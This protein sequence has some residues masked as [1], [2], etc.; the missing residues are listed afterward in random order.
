MSLSTTTGPVGFRYSEQ[1]LAQW[2]DVAQHYDLPS[3]V[4]SLS[5]VTGPA[6]RCR[7]AL[8]LARQSDNG[9][10]W[11]SQVVGEHYK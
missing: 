9:A 11:P 3:G 7:S 1:Y 10:L 2:V 5:T 4:M 8:Q 6:G